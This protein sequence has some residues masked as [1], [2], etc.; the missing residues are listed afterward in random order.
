MIGLPTGKQPDRY[1]RLIERVTEDM[2]MY[3][4]GSDEYQLLLGQLERLEE[5]RLKNKPKP[6]SR[7]TLLTVGGNLAGV[8]IM[9]AYEQHHVVTSKAVG[10]FI[11][12]KS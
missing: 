2:D 8:L 1:D 9:V 7:D 3:G 6:I 10:L 12:P 11:R 4:P 5:L